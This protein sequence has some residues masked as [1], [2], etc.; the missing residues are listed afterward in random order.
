METKDTCHEQ[1]KDGTALK[2]EEVRIEEVLLREEKAC[3][4]LCSYNEA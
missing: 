1:E 4:C 2:A 3:S